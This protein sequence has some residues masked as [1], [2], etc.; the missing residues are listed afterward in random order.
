MK[1]RIALI[2]DPKVS[3]PLSLVVEFS[4]L[5]TYGV[6]KIFLLQQSVSS[7]QTDCDHIVYLTKPSMAWMK[8]IA[9][10]VQMY[11]KLEA[12]TAA[13]PPG[14]PGS[15]AT[16]NA[17]KHFSIVFIPHR[18]VVCDRILEEEVSSVAR[19]VW[20]L[21]DIH[22]FPL[23][24]V[25]FEND[26]L[27]MEVEHSFRDLFLDGDTSLLYYAAKSLMKFQQ[28]FGHIPNIKGRGKHAQT[29]ADMLLRFT[30]EVLLTP[31]WHLMTRVDEAASRKR[32]ELR[33]GGT[34]EE[35]QPQY[36]SALI[37][38]DRTVDPLTPMCTPL[39]YEGL[40][41]E[42][43]GI[44]N[45]KIDVDEV[46]VNPAKDK[47]KPPERAAAGPKSV[48]IP[49][50]SS[51]RLFAEIRDINF[52]ALGPLLHTK[53]KAIDKNYSER[54]KAKSLQ[55]IKKF[56]AKL[57]VLQQE[58]RSLQ[59]HTNIAE[60]ILQI[61]KE[62]DFR[63]RLE[64]EHRLLSGVDSGDTRYLEDCISRAEPIGKI[65]RLL[66]LLSYT[67]GGIK[68]K[69]YDSFRREFLQT[70]GYNHIGTLSNLEQLGL[71]KK[72]DGS[73]PFASI[74]KTMRLI[75]TDVDEKDPKDIAYV[76]SGYAPLS[77]RLIEAAVKGE[78]QLKE[79]RKL[80]GM[81]S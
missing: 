49:L 55:E 7:L 33:Q 74:K 50:N 32:R 68:P 72:Y 21:V 58:H 25:P 43:F 76:Y 78:W 41:D 52:S 59:I 36:I 71:I 3:G 62:N 8:T 54:D 81:H 10:H 12:V 37:L 30:Q 14:P 22:E 11:Q 48:K 40:V 1:G 28:M 60:R 69:Q 13:A 38:L 29:V 20:G 66:C 73:P 39:T 9:E 44:K 53:A 19:G 56:V 15:A 26:V 31:P 70:Y 18:Y 61:T 16:P 79:L 64:F 75:V 42:V 27:S 24:L 80:K 5:Q 65:L 2:I 51:D 35:P 63:K 4:T 77:V 57:G 34:P 46:I 17:P 67:T 6:E 23:H 45:S 47:D